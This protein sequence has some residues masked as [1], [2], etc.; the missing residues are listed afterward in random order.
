MK[1]QKTWLMGILLGSLWLTMG[2]SPNEGESAQAQSSG[3][4]NAQEEGDRT[5]TVDVAIAEAQTRGRELNYSGS[6]QPLRRVSLRARSDGQLLTLN[7]DVGDP[8]FQGQ[9]IAQVEDTL[10]LSELA[11]VE[12][13]VSVRQSEVEEARNQ[14]IEAEFRVEELRAE[15]DQA[16]V[17]SR[18]LKNLAA[19]GAIPRRDAELAQTRVRTLEQ[20]LRSAQEQ[21]RIRDRAITSAQQRVAA[22]ETVVDGVRQRL[23][24]TDVPSP[25]NAVVLE[26]LLEPGDIVQS[27]DVILEL[28]DFSEVEIRIEIPDRD[29]SQISLGQAVDVTLDA[30]PNQEF[31]G[32]VS[33]IFPNADPVARLIPVQITLRNPQVPDGQ[34]GGGLL[35]RVTLNTTSQQVVTIPQRALEVSTEGSDTPLNTLFVVEGNESET[36]VSARR[37]ELGE[38][39][40]DDIEILQGLAPGEQFIVRSD[41]PLRDGQTV[42]RSFLSQPSNE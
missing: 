33:R 31:V 37:V 3:R 21:V 42:R 1:P 27:G 35:A 13:E 5:V 4:G 30:F 25:L 17:D 38:R 36:T 11:G 26:R 12:A 10:L 6:T 24:Y 32:R 39:E 9:V 34:L 23:S 28:G 29:R 7:A 8:V 22:Q 20:Q 18:R 16:V 40:D 2:C 41:R 19:E 15:L 14:S